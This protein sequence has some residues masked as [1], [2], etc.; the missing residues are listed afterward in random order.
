MDN[1][2]RNLLAEDHPVNCEVAEYM[3]R[4][5]GYLADVAVNGLEVLDAVKTRRYPVVLMDLRMPEMDGLEA[6]RRMIAETKLP[7]TNAS[8]SRL[9]HDHIIIVSR[10]R[11][12]HCL[13]FANSI[14][15]YVSRANSR[16][17]CEVMRSAV[18]ATPEVSRGAAGPHPWIRL[19]FQGVANKFATPWPRSRY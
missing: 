17:S 4:R 14:I 2:I 5:L 6:A 9:N 11:T 8:L 16:E 7:I 19:L 10:P 3:L 15:K 12:H 18:V 13:A 1:A